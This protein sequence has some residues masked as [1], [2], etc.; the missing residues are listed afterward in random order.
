[1]IRRHATVLRLTLAAV[2]LVTAIAVFIAV[3]VARFGLAWQDAWQAAA[4]NPW[5]L[6]VLYGVSWVV[7][8]WLLGLYR[9][10]ARW[11]WRTEWLD[12]L[13][14]VLL[15][16]F[17]AFAFLYVAKLPNVSRLFL[18]EL[19]AA[20]A[21][22]AVGSRGALRLLF[23]WAR[24]NGRNTRYVL[25]VGDGPVAHDFARRIERQRLPRTPDRW[26]P[27]GPESGRSATWG[28]SEWA[29]ARP[30]VDVTPGELPR[31]H[32]PDRNHPPLDGR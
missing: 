17:F 4:A 16:A 32:R 30:R 13:R 5:V 21:V 7:I 9:L 24:R 20:Q 28:E 2:D 8:L 26:F 23:A 27:C 3:S 1:M 14:A 10:R 6:G 31:S 11:S 12:L 29:G 18:L 22:V 19:F 25:V 15:F